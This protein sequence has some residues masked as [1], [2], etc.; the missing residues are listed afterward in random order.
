M[1]VD[2]TNYIVFGYKLP[3]SIFGDS[4][5]DDFYNKFEDYIESTYDDKYKKRLLSI[6]ADGMGGKYVVVGKIIDRTD[7]DC[8]CFSNNFN[9]IPSSIITDELVK[10]LKEEFVRLFPKYAELAD[11]PQY[12]IFSHC[13]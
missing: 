1:G 11:K 2:T 10:Q 13:S 6:I 3:Y 5:W 7:S 12:L 9:V 4:E 8:Y